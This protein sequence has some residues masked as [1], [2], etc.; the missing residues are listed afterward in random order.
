[1]KIGRG[2]TKKEEGEYR[3]EE[4]RW[5]IEEGR[6]G[7]ETASAAKTLRSLRRCG[8]RTINYETDI[9]SALICESVLTG[10]ICGK[11]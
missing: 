7:G 1:V 9:I 2:N 4:G 8:K 6:K 10:G 3:R 5:K 11:N